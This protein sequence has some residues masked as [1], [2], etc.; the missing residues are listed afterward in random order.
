MSHGAEYR[1]GARTD[2]YTGGPSSREQFL[3]RGLTAKNAVN[4]SKSNFRSLIGAKRNLL[5]DPAGYERNSS[6]VP[7]RHRDLLRVFTDAI[8]RQRKHRKGTTM[9][10]TR[11]SLMSG[12]VHSMEIAVNPAELDAYHAGQTNI[13]DVLPKLKAARREFIT[14]G[15]TPDEWASLGEGE[16]TSG[17]PSDRQQGPDTFLWVGNNMGAALVNSARGRA[18]A[19]ITKMEGPYGV[20]LFLGWPSRLRFWRRLL[21]AERRKIAWGRACRMEVEFEGMFEAIIETDQILEAL[22]VIPQRVERWERYY[23][24]DRRALS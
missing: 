19:L 15:I 23:L 20:R 5:F 6:L 18:D 7:G 17:A 10:I 11:K 12:K 2:R 4:P 9:R 22:G 24:L 8:R 13:Q 1:D 16:G 3:L 14:T 21:I